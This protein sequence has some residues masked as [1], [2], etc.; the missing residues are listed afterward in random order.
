MFS[1]LRTRLSTFNRLSFSRLRFRTGRL[2]CFTRVLGAD[3]ANRRATIFCFV[4]LSSDVYAIDRSHAAKQFAPTILA[5]A[6]E[7]APL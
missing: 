5:C 7:R 6:C 2:P 4:F 3:F 1:R